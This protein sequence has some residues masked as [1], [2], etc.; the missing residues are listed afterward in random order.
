MSP[1]F[2]KIPLSVVDI[3]T[4]FEDPLIDEWLD[5]ARRV[6]LDITFYVHRM[7]MPE[8]SSSQLLASS[9]V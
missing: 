7:D 6:G 8:F 3:D 4:D 1:W 2:S 9:R 5:S